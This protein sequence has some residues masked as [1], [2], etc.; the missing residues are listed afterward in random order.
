MKAM[1][2]PSS[3]SQSLLPNPNLLVLDRIEI[4]PTQLHL[5][6]HAA[7][8]PVCPVCGQVSWSRHSGYRRCLQD[9]P[10]QG[11]AVQLWLTVRRFRCRNQVCPCR[12]FCERLPGVTQAHSRQTDR[13]FE[14]VRFVGYLAGGR[15][16]QQ[17]LLRLS[18]PISDD[19]V[20]RR[21]RQRSGFRLSSGVALGR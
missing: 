12:I 13:T 2:R 21:V 7:Q 14:I 15:P 19:T 5:L 1:A 11:R 8:Q 10:W 6:V 20:L 17:L 4:D 18:L 16:G 9:L 3:P